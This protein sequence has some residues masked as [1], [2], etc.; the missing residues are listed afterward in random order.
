M[1]LILGRFLLKGH[2]GI[3]LNSGTLGTLK[4]KSKSKLGISTQKASSPSL[5]KA[6]RDFKDSKDFKA[7]IPPKA[8]MPSPKWEALEV[9]TTFLLLPKTSNFQFLKISA[10]SSLL[11]PSPSTKA[12]TSTLSLFQVSKITLAYDVFT[13]TVMSLEALKL[14]L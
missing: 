11:R 6:F 5:F 13:D 8:A 10:F 7:S 4:L 14:S 1:C 3:S 12:S 2:S 9:I